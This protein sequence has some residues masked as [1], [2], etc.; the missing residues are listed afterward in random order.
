MAWGEG[1]CHCVPARVPGAAGWRVGALSPFRSL[2]P[3][4]CVSEVLP[5]HAQNSFHVRSYFHIQVD[6]MQNILFFE[7]LIS[8]GGIRSDPKCACRRKPFRN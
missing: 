1:P 2:Q 8:D 5:C 4:P 7:L 6:G 3:F